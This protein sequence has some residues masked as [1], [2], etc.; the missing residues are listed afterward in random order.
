[1]KNL[2]QRLITGFF[3]IAAIIS[4]I[5]WG[6]LPFQWL[7]FVA[8]IGSLH[9][10]YVLVQNDHNRPNRT[11]GLLLGAATYLLI[12]GYAFEMVP[13]HFLILLAPFCA[14]VFIA[15]LY[16]NQASPFGNIGYTL[17]GIVYVM[18]PFALLSILSVHQGTYDRGLLLG[19]FFLVWSSDSFAYVFGNLFGKHRLFERISPKKSWEG[20]I[21]GGVST[22]GIAYLLS[23]YQTQ[24]S[25]IHWLM[26]AFIIVVTGILGD[27]VE[28][29]LK[30]SLGVKDSGNIL[31]GHGGLLDRFDA[32]FLSIPFIWAYLACFVNK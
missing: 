15:E 12:T 3:F 9:E 5:W 4:S 25:T 14:L 17:L 21:G 27:L 24:L 8:A 18:V 23:Q 1:M 13:P 6:P 26:I 22:L 11:L 7:F 32:L 28:S 20:V 31:P 29:L 16:R 30:R 19:Y 10:F 2:W